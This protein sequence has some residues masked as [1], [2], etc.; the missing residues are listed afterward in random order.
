MVVDF[1]TG[2]ADKVINYHHCNH[3]PANRQ[4]DNKQ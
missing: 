4:L 1:S 2:E 3:Q